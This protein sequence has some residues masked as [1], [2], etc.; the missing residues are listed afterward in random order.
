MAYNGFGDVLQPLLVHKGEITEK[1]QQYFS[2]DVRFLH[3]RNGELNY[4][5]TVLVL[6][7][8]NEYVLSIIVINM[9]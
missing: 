3:T 7:Q 6:E 2:P 5:A 1:V 4:D 9:K 8:V